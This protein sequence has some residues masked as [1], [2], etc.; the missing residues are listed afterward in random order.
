MLFVVG[1]QSICD[2]DFTVNLGKYQKNNSRLNNFGSRRRGIF[3]QE[4]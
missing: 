4:G 2:G 3:A 1:G